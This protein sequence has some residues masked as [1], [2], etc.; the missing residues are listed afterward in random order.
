MSDKTFLLKYKDF[1]FFSVREKRVSEIMR[2]FFTKVHFISVSTEYDGSTVN[3][4]ISLGPF[5]SKTFDDFKTAILCG[6][7]T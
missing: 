7:Q 5:V 1:L 6:F 2:S 4:K 3:T